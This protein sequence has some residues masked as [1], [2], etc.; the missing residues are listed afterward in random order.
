[1]KPYDVISIEAGQKSR[2]GRPK[3]FSPTRILVPVDSSGNAFNSLAYT[4]RLAKVWN[5][6]IHLFYIIDIDE[7]PY[8]ESAVMVEGAMNRLESKASICLESLRELIQ[9]MGVEVVTAE[10]EIGRVKSLLRKKIETARPDLIVSGRR[11]VHKSVL[12]T[13]VR[14]ASC[15]VL[16][17]PDAATPKVPASVLLLN[18]QEELSDLQ[19]GSMEAVLKTSRQLHILTDVGGSLRGTKTMGGEAYSIHLHTFEGT[20]P[21]QAAQQFIQ[22]HS[23][24]LVCSLLPEQSFLQRILGRCMPLELALRINIPVLI[25]R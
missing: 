4:L 11:G 22:D 23:I 13:L 10:S 12:K 14:Q 19:R 1:M 7:V 16:I 18:D 25:I 5:A 3:S 21:L 2:N 6:G 9:E 24:D 8:S 20:E 15:P 17:V